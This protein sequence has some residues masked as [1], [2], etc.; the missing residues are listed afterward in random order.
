METEKMLCGWCDEETDEMDLRS[1]PD[2]DDQ[3]DGWICPECYKEADIYWAAGEED[4]ARGEAEEQEKADAADEQA[5]DRS[6]P[7]VQHHNDTV[8]GYYLDGQRVIECAYGTGCQMCAST[9]WKELKLHGA[10]SCT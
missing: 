2:P 1:P 6:S 9:T 3:D 4:R 5:Y 10:I 8:H 7:D